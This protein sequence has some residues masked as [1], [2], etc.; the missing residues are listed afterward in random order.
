VLNLSQP[1][2][3]YGPSFMWFAETMIT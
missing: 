3:G 1:G 2:S